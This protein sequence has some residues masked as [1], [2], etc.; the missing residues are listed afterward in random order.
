MK[1]KLMHHVLSALLLVGLLL[2]PAAVAAMDKMAEN[3]DGML[4]GAKGHR[5]NGSV[6]LT[7]GINGQAMLTLSNIKV[8]R[9]PDGY[10]YL[11]K[12]GDH[13]Q[14]VVLG[15]L[16]QFRGTVQFDVPPG[17]DTAAYNSVVIW[18]EK[19]SVEIGRAYLPKKMMK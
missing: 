12:D 17:T 18:C 6:A 3:P 5:A 13:T 11:A 15:M 4:T 10:V 2:G 9:V 7:T 19:Y 8:D 16:K 1:T 14:G